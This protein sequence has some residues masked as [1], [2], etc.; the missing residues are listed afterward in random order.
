M[1]KMPKHQSKTSINKSFNI[2]RLII[3]METRDSRW[4][5]DE[6]RLHR[7]N[8][9]PAVIGT[10]GDMDWYYHGKLNR[11]TGPAKT[12]ANG[13]VKYYVRDVSLPD[14]KTVQALAK[15]IIFM[16]NLPPERKQIIKLYTRNYDSINKKLDRP[17]NMSIIEKA[18]YSELMYVFNEIP[19]L[20]KDITLYRGIDEKPFFNE[21]IPRISSLTYDIGAAVNFTNKKCC[22]LKIKI[23]KGSK[24]I[25][26]LADDITFF[27]PES[28]CLLPPNGTW[29]VTRVDT[30]H[31]VTRGR[32]YKFDT[33]IK[34][35]SLTYTSSGIINKTLFPSSLIR[36]ARQLIDILLSVEPED[37]ISLYDDC[38][39]WDIKPEIHPMYEYISSLI[40]ILGYD[41]DPVLVIDIIKEENLEERFHL[42]MT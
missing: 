38:S 21:S 8:D 26:M 32:Y 39:D 23:S 34:E 36:F 13:N 25:P 2:P 9:L 15:Q 10:N 35:Y 19:P 5:D 30:K 20:K 4:Y 41:I 7:D 27:V 33:N 14:L 42:L 12:K 17:L 40:K 16:D 24:L 22:L 6:G 18:V 1:P 11:V 28:E 29:K 31:I 3:Y 37:Y